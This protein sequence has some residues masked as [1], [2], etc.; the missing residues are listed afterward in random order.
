MLGRDKLDNPLLTCDQSNFNQIT[1]RSRD[2]TLVTVVRDTCTTTVPPPPII[3]HSCNRCCP[4]P[5]WLDYLNS[6]QGYF[7]P[8]SASLGMST[9]GEIP[10]DRHMLVFT[11]KKNN[12]YRKNLKLTVSCIDKFCFWR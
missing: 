11:G 10:L 1:A 7:S 8:F 4:A 6:D 2:R 12:L 3:P 5:Y 9:T